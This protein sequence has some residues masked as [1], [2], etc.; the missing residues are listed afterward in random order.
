MVLS[1]QSRKPTGVI[2]RYIMTRIFVNCN[3][4]L[5]SF[6]KEMLDLKKDDR[7]L[8]IG[9]GPGALI[10]E[11]ATITT[12]GVVEGIDFSQTMLKHAAKVN[13]KHISEGKVRLQKGECSALPFEDESFDNLCSINTLYF[14][15]EPEKYFSE[16]FRVIKPGGKLVIGFR[17]DEQMSSLNLSKDIFNTYSQDGVISL[18]SNAGFSGSHI[19]EKAGAPFI[20]YCA[21]ATKV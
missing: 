7:V 6:V 14:W 21:V 8:E 13:K 3:A 2:G 9:F 20:S 17:D 18:L 12:E 4:D 10:C 5:N 11:M 1:L 19:K 16:M 15:K